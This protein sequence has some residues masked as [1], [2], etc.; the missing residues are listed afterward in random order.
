[1][2]D[3]ANAQWDTEMINTTPPFGHIFATHGRES[4]SLSESRVD[5]EFDHNLAIHRFSE[6]SFGLNAST[7]TSSA[8]EKSFKREDYIY[9]SISFLSFLPPDLLNDGFPYY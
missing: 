8:A 9:V 6:V 5:E 2:I 1:M 7:V 4:S 3:D